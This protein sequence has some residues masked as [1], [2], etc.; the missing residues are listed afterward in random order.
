MLPS[1]L[2][3]FQAVMGNSRDYQFSLML[4]RDENELALWNDLF[5]MDPPCPPDV[6]DLSPN[7]PPLLRGILFLLCMT[8]G[9]CFFGTFMDSLEKGS[10]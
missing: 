4:P 1:T 2:A 7:V 8:C 5:E 3:E 10:F 9:A 6:P